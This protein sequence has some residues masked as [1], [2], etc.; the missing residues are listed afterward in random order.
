MTLRV[1]IVTTHPIQYQVPWFRALA[2]EA[3]IDL[4]VFYGQLPDG[5]LQGD[6]FGVSFEWDTPL[7]D[8]YR[9]Q[10]LPNVA[11]RPS[12]TTFWGCDTPALHDIIRRGQFDAVIVNGWV[13]KSCLQALVACRRAGVPC[14]VRGESNAM[15][16]RAWWKRMIHRQLLHQYAAFL[17]I[18]SSNAEFYRSHGIPPQRMFP[19]RYC[20]DNA[21]FAS[22]ADS[23]RRD[24]NG[25]RAAWGIE[26]DVPVFLF[27]GKFIP[28]KHPL[29]LLRAASLAHRRG[30]RLHLLL[31]GDGELRNDCER[32]AHEMQLPA[33]FAGF[34][35]QSRLPEAYVASDCLVL[36]SDDGETWGLVVNEAMACGVPAVVSD[37]A[38][39]G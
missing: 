21:R 24:R 9:Y 25:L 22:A 11:K 30:A 23:L 15:R 33:T 19:G 3:E 35:N 10:V 26:A 29:T 34:I 20:V 27:C 32:I 18:G 16:R 12:V 28:K 2:A 5:S 14:I 6:G 4:T 39:C 38:G 1:G 31:V 37:R 36:P 8:G 17:V 7:L 13:A